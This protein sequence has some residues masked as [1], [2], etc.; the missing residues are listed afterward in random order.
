MISRG[1][2]ILAGV[3]GGAD[4][5][6][7]LLILY[8]LRARLGIT[9]SAVHVNH[10]IREEA[11]EDAAFTAD[12]CGQL[13]IPFYLREIDVPSAKAQTGMSEEE[14]ARLLRYEAFE[15]LQKDI[16][17]DKIA[18]AHNACDQAETMIMNM[19][20]GSGLRGMTGIRSVRGTI[21]R[22]LL[23]TDR[24]EIEDYLQAAGRDYVTDRTNLEDEHTRNRIRHH[25][26]PL[27]TESVNA[28]AVRHMG[29][30]SSDLA[31]I[32][33][34]LDRMADDYLSANAC[35]KSDNAGGRSYI[36]ELGP[37]RELDPV[38][39]KAVIK[40][41]LLAVTESAKD[42]GRVHIDA[43]MELCR[44]R[45]GEKS[46]NLPYGLLCRRSYDRLYLISGPIEAGEMVGR[47]EA[48]NAQ[49][50]N[51]TKEYSSKDIF[52]ENALVTNNAEAGRALT[53]KEKHDDAEILEA[54]EGD[55]FCSLKHIHISPSEAESYI[56]RAPRSA[57][58]KWV[59]YDTI[60]SGL[61][62]RRRMSGD[63]F[64]FDRQGHSKALSKFMTDEKVPASMRDQVDLL[65][66]GENII[67]AVGLRLSPRYEVTPDTRDILEINYYKKTR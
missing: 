53:I 3:S 44:D 32:S 15:Q 2:H 60:K 56:S 8:E 21:I 35:Y 11:G 66:D 52:D 57:Y 30:L 34:F 50:C 48:D 9:L 51:R 36:V 63:R 22:P 65:A 59:D 47:G 67:W 54:R 23:S 14:A 19:A 55:A 29:E 4:S 5:V 46:L 40:R 38:V 61:S 1:D 27:L 39:Q 25:L 45:A 62:L 37:F 33:D 42:I 6:C 49:L 7:L 64:F 58:T 17:A 12:L 18:V 31:Q 28:G 10:G 20:R 13:G 43:I 41:S 24:Q 26:L 16:S